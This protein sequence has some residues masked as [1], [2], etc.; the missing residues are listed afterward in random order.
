MNASDKLLQE[1][2]SKAAAW[3]REPFDSQTRSAVSKMIKT[4]ND[5][6]I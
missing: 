4:E 3:T 1:V 5:E 2:K 6:L